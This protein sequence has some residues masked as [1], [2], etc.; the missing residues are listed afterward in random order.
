MSDRIRNI[1]D[2]IAY[3]IIGVAVV[4]V[5]ALSA[6]ARADA[7]TDPGLYPD[8]RHQG[9]T[10]AVTS[11]AGL[12]YT[13][14]AYDPT[15]GGDRDPCVFDPDPAGNPVAVEPDND[16]VPR[17]TLAVTTRTSIAGV[18]VPTT[19]STSDPGRSESGDVSVGGV[20]ED[21]PRFDC[22]TMG[23]GVCGPGA[24]HPAGCYVRKG[25]TARHMIRPWDA[26]MAADQHYRPDGCGKRTT[27]DLRMDRFL[28]G[29]VPQT[30]SPNSRGGVT[31]SWVG[32]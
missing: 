6:G 24:N 29:A 13:C 30:C 11:G 2:V 23:N 26:A 25:R 14:A 9:D 19:M 27:R 1:L 17:W 15:D 5:G 21:S 28:S 7:T 16:P 32:A 31:C 8:G 20:A 3:V 4:A 18:V 10:Y 12:P 22:R